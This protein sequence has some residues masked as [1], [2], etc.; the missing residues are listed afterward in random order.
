MPNNTSMLLKAATAQYNT[1]YL[2]RLQKMLD[3]IYIL[4]KKELTHEI[5][6]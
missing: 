2:K 1:E 5:I 4:K 3:A 6:N